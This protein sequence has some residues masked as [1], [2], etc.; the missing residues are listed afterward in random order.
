MKTNFKDYLKEK[1]YSSGTRIS[2]QNAV[3]Y[4]TKWLDREGLEAEA[5]SY[6]DALAYIKKSKEQ[7]N[8]RSIQSQLIG[9][10]HYYHYLELPNPFERIKL[11]GVK[12]RSLYTILEPHQLHGLYANYKVESHTSVHTGSRNKTILGL[13]VYQGLTIKEMAG[14]QVK[15]VALREG[16]V[17]VAGSR[18]SNERTLDLERYQV[19][20]MYEYVMQIRKGSADDKLFTNKNLSDVVHKLIARINKG[21]TSPISLRQLRAS[22]I[23]KWLKAYNLREAQYRSGH[24]YISSTEAY[25][26]NE[27][28]GLKEE[29]EQYHPLG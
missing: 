9:I 18:K 25:L 16:T 29:I 6:G 12:K 24:R 10:K 1:G 4:F 20:D 27:V 26:R 19:M 21:N 14:L 8:Q 3:S 13:L 17:Y 11:Q 5:V 28:D 7:Q 23:V 22:V 15:D 2:Y